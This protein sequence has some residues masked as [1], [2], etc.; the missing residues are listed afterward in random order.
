MLLVGLAVVT[1][2]ANS[3]KALVKTY[4]DHGMISEI[5]QF[6]FDEHDYVSFESSRSDRGFSVVHDPKCRR[7]KL[8]AY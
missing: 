8:N 5:H 6:T 7:C 3:D 2:C 4:N 1:S